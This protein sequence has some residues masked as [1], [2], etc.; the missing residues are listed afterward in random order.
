[1]PSLS[2]ASVCPNPVTSQAVPLMTWSLVLS[3]AA[4]ASE[5]TKSMGTPTEDANSSFRIRLKTRTLNDDH[6]CNVKDRD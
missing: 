5:D 1:M 6:S 4:L 2:P 3:P